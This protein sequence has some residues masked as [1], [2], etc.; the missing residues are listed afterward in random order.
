MIASVL[1]SRPDYTL[2]NI[3][4]VVVVTAAGVAAA[5]ALRKPKDRP[6]H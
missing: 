4:A 6:G 3:F 2:V 1:A 5:V